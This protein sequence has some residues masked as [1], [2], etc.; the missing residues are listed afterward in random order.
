VAHIEENDIRYN[1]NMGYDVGIK[2]GG[3]PSNVGSGLFFIGELSVNVPIVR[4]VFEGDAVSLMIGPGI[5]FYPIQ[6]LQLGSSFG[7]SY[8]LAPSA[9]GCAYN[10]SAAYD[11]YKRERNYGLLFGIKYYS[12]YGEFENLH[13]SRELKSSMIS[14]FVKY[15]YRKRAASLTEEKSY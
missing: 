13:E 1:G 14:I 6:N 2:V 15:T 3:G 8:Y 4:P 12:A 7:L 10:L 11:F 9:L 5:I